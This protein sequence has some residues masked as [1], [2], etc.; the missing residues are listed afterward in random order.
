MQKL[1]NLDLKDSKLTLIT[2]AFLPLCAI[3]SISAEKNTIRM[4]LSEIEE[5]I[6][7]AQVTIEEQ[8]KAVEMMVAPTEATKAP[9][10]TIVVMM[11][12]TWDLP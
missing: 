9:T 8:E 3:I 2:F 7:A 5:I 11:K 12:R 10:A 1:L 6:E 4:D